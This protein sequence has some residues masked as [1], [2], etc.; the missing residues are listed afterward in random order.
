MIIYNVTLNVDESIHATWLSWMNQEHIPAMLNTGKFYKALFTKVLV[1]EDMGGITY[2][3]QYTAKSRQDLDDYY[4]NF[5]EQLRAQGKAFE[6]KVLAFRT[7][8]EIVSEH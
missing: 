1:E 2:S 5:A 4:A 8:L 7:E 6:G 3:V